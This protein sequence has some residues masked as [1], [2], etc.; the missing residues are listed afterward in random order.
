MF[1][2]NSIR[3]KKSPYFRRL[4]FGHC[5]K[6]T[7]I[8]FFSFGKQ[9]Q[10]FSLIEVLVAVSILAVGLVFIVQSMAHTQQ[11]LR[12]SENISRAAYIAEEELVKME[13]KVREFERAS[14]GGESGKVESPGRLLEWESRVNV[15]NH[16]SLKDQSRAN[17]LAVF[18]EWRESNRRNNLEV[19]TMTIDRKKK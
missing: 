17:K 8:S 9:E 4:P 11:A 14:F 19:Q 12:L 15:F 6:N 16:E 5:G 3:K 7:G 1:L 13:I 18:V 2:P 10:G